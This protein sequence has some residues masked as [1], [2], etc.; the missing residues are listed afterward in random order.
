MKKFSVRARS[1]RDDEKRV[2]DS[3]EEPNSNQNYPRDT[4]KGMAKILVSKNYPSSRWNYLTRDLGPV[5]IPS[6]NQ[7]RKN[8]FSKYSSKQLASK[9]D[10]DVVNEVLDFKPSLKIDPSVNE[11][12]SQK[13]PD[14]PG[15]NSRNANCP[16]SESQEPVIT[17]DNTEVSLNDNKQI[18]EVSCKLNKLNDIY[19]IDNHS[20]N[21]MDQDD[22]LVLKKI[23][24]EETS[25]DSSYSIV[26]FSEQRTSNESLD[27]I[28]ETITTSVV[29]KIKIKA[30]SLKNDKSKNTYKV[31]R[32]LPIKPTRADLHKA[33]LYIADVIKNQP[34][35][36]FTTLVKK[37][38]NSPI[39]RETKNSEKLLSD[40][41]Q[42]VVIKFAAVQAENNV[43]KPKATT[44][45][46]SA[47]VNTDKER[48]KLLARLTGEKKTLSKVVFVELQT[49]NAI[50]EY[51]VIKKSLVQIFGLLPGEF[52]GVTKTSDPKVYAFLMEESALLK[53]AKDK[54]C[55]EAGVIKPWNHS[56]V[57]ANRSLTTLICKSITENKTRNVNLRKNAE[58]I[59][60]TLRDGDFLA[61]EEFNLSF[62]QLDRFNTGRKL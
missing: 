49:T 33:A 7:S 6:K 42:Q 34:T 11:N 31:K 30:Q 37:I 35:N 55:P 39:M 18:N 53:Y 56:E 36:K 26:E 14:C 16:E 13:F 58:Y 60:K 21:L 9:S 54:P 45:T 28:S 61:D 25:S 44:A 40:M 15:E 59:F 12:F 48:V 38:F 5:T 10:L 57:S 2:S 32:K 22:H 46:E 4:K 43:A 50:A 8:T 52:A 51:S 20:E 3:S 17:P 47:R 41:L 23:K 27:I 29:K 24:V 1:W 62:F 19:I